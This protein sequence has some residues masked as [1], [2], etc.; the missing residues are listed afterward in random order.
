M[1]ITDTNV[2]RIELSADEVTR[3]A[4]EYAEH[5]FHNGVTEGES[6]G[7]PYRAD[8]PAA[9]QPWK[10]STE[11]ERRPDGGAVVTITRTR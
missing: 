4:V 3:A 9:Q 7:M 10:K 6:P 5:V 11:T 2:T 1:K 8:A